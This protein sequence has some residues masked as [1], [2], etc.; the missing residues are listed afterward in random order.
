MRERDLQQVKEVDYYKALAYK[1]F[2][3]LQKKMYP[4]VGC[5]VKSALQETE[6]LIARSEADIDI[7]LFDM[8]GTVNQ[9]GA[10]KLL[11]N[12]HYIFCPLTSD[13]SV[14]VSSVDFIVKIKQLIMDGGIGSLQK[15]FMFWNEVD[16][17]EK[18]RV[19]EMCEKLLAKFQL[20]VL[21]TKI[22]YLLRFRKEITDTTDIFRCTVFPASPNLLRESRVDLFVGEICSKI[23]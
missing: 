12:M 21:E 6:N 18:T 14:V 3:S 1:Q 7:V 9:E 23:K 16:A 17:R 10:I 11:A 4:V 22:P 5:D 19:Y 15:V 20:P 2:T 8:P 13:R